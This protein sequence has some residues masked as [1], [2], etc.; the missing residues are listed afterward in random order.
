MKMKK[1][2]ILFIIFFASI[3]QN[4]FAQLNPSPSQFYFNKLQQNVAAT[5]FDKGIRIDASYRNF[6]P[7]GF[8]G[9]PVNIYFG[10]QSSVGERSGVGLQ[11]QSENAGLLSRSRMLGSYAIDFGN[12]DLHTRIGVGFGFMFARINQ[13]SPLFRG[14]VN[15]PFIAQFNARQ[16]KLD[17]SIGIQIESASGWSFMASTPSVGSIQQFSNYEAIDYVLLTSTV[18]KKITLSGDEDDQISIAPLLGYQLLQGVAGVFQSGALIDYRNWI[19]FMGMYYS[20]S[21]YSAG[22]SIPVKSKLALNF[23]FNSGKIYGKGLL[24]T[25]GTMEAHIMYRLGE[26]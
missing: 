5:G 20:N 7:N 1:I 9:S 2:N 18:S 3:F 24:N 14:D 11:F 6:A 10:A 19:K 22:V 8:V 13:S 23:I 16:L 12:E 21:E 4:G 26:N 25:G 15:D 17:G